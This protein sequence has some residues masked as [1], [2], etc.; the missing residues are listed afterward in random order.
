MMGRTPK[1]DHIA[2]HQSLSSA[3]LDFACWRR[4]I[5][6]SIRRRRGHVGLCLVFCAGHAGLCSRL[7]SRLGHE[8]TESAQVNAG[9]ATNPVTVYIGVGTFLNL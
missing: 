7:S 2:G 3:S 6:S 8:R 4:A 1:A 5:T 9:C